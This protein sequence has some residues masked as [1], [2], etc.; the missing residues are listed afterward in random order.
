MP[1]M[2]CL[3]DHSST[4]W[5]SPRDGEVF[6]VPAGYVA[7]LEDAGLARLVDEPPP[8]PPAPGEPPAPPAPGEDVHDAIAKLQATVQPERRRGRPP[9]NGR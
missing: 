7:Q 4:L 8:A 9:K 3:R 5:G 1:K 6:E 2:R